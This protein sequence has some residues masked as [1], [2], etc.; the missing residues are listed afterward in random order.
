[1]RRPTWR[2][3]PEFALSDGWVMTIQYLLI[4]AFVCV[5]NLETFKTNRKF[6]EDTLT[7]QVPSFSETSCSQRPLEGAFWDS[8]EPGSQGHDLIK[9]TTGSAT[10]L[11]ELPGK[12]G[13]WRGGGLFVQA[14]RHLRAF[15][16]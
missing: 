7:G 6:H 5:G 3:I 10:F 13:G 8:E 9:N 2:G 12:E 11:K 1:M 14:P 15:S 4:G 16:H